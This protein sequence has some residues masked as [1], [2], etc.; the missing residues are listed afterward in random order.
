MQYRPIYIERLGFA[1]VEEI[2]KFTTAERL[3]NYY[4]MLYE[5]L[6]SKIFEACTEQ[7]KRETGDGTRVMQ[8]CTILDLKDIKLSNASAAYKFVKPASEMAQ[9]NY[10]EILG[11]MFILNAPF[12]F[13]GIWAIVKMWIDDKTKE[14][15][16]ILGSSYKKELLKY[17][18]PENLPDFLEGGTCKCKKGCLDINIGPWNPEGEEFFPH[19]LHEVKEEKEEKTEKVEINTTEKGETEKVE[20][21]EKERVFNKKLEL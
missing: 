5:T 10:P 3:L 6:L 1:N 13:T 15:I 20:N 14:K 21:E 8:T 7:K 18:D 2:W 9:N 17:V 16:Q 11:N 12:L 4:G 19:C